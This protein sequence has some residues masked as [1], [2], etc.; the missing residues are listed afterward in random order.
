MSL[1]VVDPGFTN[2]VL[3]VGDTKEADVKIIKKDAASS[4]DRTTADC[5]I[6]KDGHKVLLGDSSV[7]TPS[8]G[9]LEDKG[10]EWWNASLPTIVSA[11]TA[12]N[13][14]RPAQS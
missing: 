10:S 12:D 6:V 1:L 8:K 7:D 11:A 9:S 5:I 14:G 4:W 3:M 2:L 13:T